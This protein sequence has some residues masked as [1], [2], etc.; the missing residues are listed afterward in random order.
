M[1]MSNFLSQ[2]KDAATVVGQIEGKIAAGV[3]A[4]ADE[5]RSLLNGLVGKLKIHLA[6]EDKNIYPKAAESSDPTL[7]Q[8]SVK[9]QQEMDGLAGAL[10]AYSQKWMM[11]ATIK[12]QPDAF[13][14]ETKAVFDALKKRITVEERDFYPLCAKSL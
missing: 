4:N 3:A 13:A 11:A 7:K 14:A 12:A 6:M 8:M 9:L 1:D 5:I 2:H 10:V